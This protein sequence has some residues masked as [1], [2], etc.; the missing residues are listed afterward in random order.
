MLA[1]IAAIVAS[2][3]SA[4][5]LE[6]SVVERSPLSP[7]ELWKEVDD[8][9]GLP[10]WDSAVEQCT[11]SADG[12]RRTI[13]SFGGVFRLE[14]ELED[15]NEANRSI[16]WKNISESASIANY[17]ARVSVIAD[18]QGSVL[19][20][21]ASYEARGIPDVKARNVT[22]TGA[23]NCDLKTTLIPRFR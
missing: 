8:F 7:G 3:S 16:G 17:H 10:A 19:T 18:G 9:C 21:T 23:L 1:V 11:L 2:M 12:K 4:H 20:W 15:W 13:R 14:A 5:A 22:A 6:S